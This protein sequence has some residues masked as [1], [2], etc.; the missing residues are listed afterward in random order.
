MDL[1]KSRNNTDSFYRVYTGQ[2]LLGNGNCS[3]STNS[4]TVY[5]TDQ[6]HYYP[7]LLP[8][9]TRIEK[10]ALR[11]GANSSGALLKIG[12]YTDL[13]FFPNTKLAE[14]IMDL[15]AAGNLKEID[16]N[17]T[18]SSGI[19]W[20]GHIFN[21][22]G[23]PTIVSSSG[24]QGFASVMGNHNIGSSTAS[25]AGYRRET[26]TSYATG[27]PAIATQE[28]TPSWLNTTFP[29]IFYKVG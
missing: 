2:Y 20:T 14:G 22:S 5:T 18:L 6:I 12:L 19:Y 17:L 1:I 15:G 24:T 26:G 21:G 4:S 28:S 7:F 23:S 10:L 9:T 13:N 8:V 27:L 3:S 11:T 25:G 16:V 29:L